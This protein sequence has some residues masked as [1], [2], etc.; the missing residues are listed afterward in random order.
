MGPYDLGRRRTRER[1]LL[2]SGRRKGPNQGE[3][4]T[5]KHAPN[6]GSGTRA[7]NGGPDPESRRGSTG[8]DGSAG[9]RVRGRAPPSAAQGRIRGWPSS[10]RGRSRMDERPCPDRCGGCAAMRIPTVTGGLGNDPSYPAH[11]TRVI[12]RPCTVSGAA[13]A[14]PAGF[15][16]KATSGLCP[17]MVAAMPAHDVSME[18]FLGA[19]R[20]CVASPR[21]CATSAW[22]GIAGPWRVSPVPDR[23]KRTAEN[24]GGP[25]WRR[26]GRGRCGRPCGRSRPAEDRGTR[27]AAA[28]GV[29]RGAGAERDAAQGRQ[30]VPGS[31]RAVRHPEHTDP[32]ADRRPAGEADAEEPR[33]LRHPALADG[34]PG[35]DGQGRGEAPHTQRGRR[36][37]GPE[38]L[39]DPRP[40][41]TVQGADLCH[42]RR[43]P[44]RCRAV[45][46]RVSHPP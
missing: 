43:R 44:R 42:R 27:A 20:S 41:G 7:T 28:R 40:Q 16:S 6:A 31:A 15:G 35:R 29:R 4:G 34:R 8:S 33:P 17:A 11:R 19:V 23:W 14:M 32:H 24:R 21:R 30:G 26:R 25:R 46:P 39:P 9:P 36:P 18:P 38:Q 2:R 10:T 37:C 12:H 45:G 22:A 5:P 13:G 3:F 1:P